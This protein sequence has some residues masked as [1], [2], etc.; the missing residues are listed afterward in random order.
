MM[1]NIIVSELKRVISGYP[2]RIILTTSLMFILI[3][4]VPVVDMGSSSFPSKMVSD[5]ITPVLMASPQI[6]TIS[7]R[8]RSGETASSLLNTYMPLKTIYN[9]DNMAK[10][11]FPLTGLRKGQPY[12]ISLLEDSLVA[13]EY[14]IDRNDRLLI[15]KE[16]GSYSI[17]KLPIEYQIKQDVVSVDIRSS[18]AEAVKRAGESSELTWK[19]ADIFAWDIDFMRDIQPGDQF[20]ALVEKKYRDDK[21]YGY[22]DVKAAFFTN[23][24]NTYRAFLHENTAGIKGYFDEKGTSLQKAFL[25]APLNYSRISSSFSKRRFHPIL[26]KYRAH[27]GVDYAAPRNTPIKTVADGVITSINYSKTTGRQITIRHFN[28]YETKYF[29]M[30][31]YAKGMKKN[32]KVTQ[33]DIIGYVGKT[34]LATGYHLCFRMRKNGRPVNPLKQKTAS[35]KPVSDKEKDHFSFLATQFTQRIKAHQKLAASTP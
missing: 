7:G 18:L 19:L 33:G 23:K 3:S 30:N 29:H 28:G 31:K 16:E 27:S 26:K 9:I 2:K 12:K 5:I 1:G 8:V 4:A 21:F 35:A 17:T 11:I 20:E 22:S 10:P 14:E 6:K 32:K 15:S 24:G 25:K 13:F 34:G